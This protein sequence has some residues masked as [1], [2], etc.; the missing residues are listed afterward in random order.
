MVW[1]YLKSWNFDVDGFSDPVEALGYFQNNPSFF[2]LALCD[3]F[4][5]LGVVFCIGRG[6]CTSGATSFTRRN[7][8]HV[9]CFCLNVIA[10]SHMDRSCKAIHG[11]RE[12][13]G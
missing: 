6:I 5:V 4:D 7:V 3:V 1:M 8:C 11:K 12:W 13:E 9:A 10:C 2:S